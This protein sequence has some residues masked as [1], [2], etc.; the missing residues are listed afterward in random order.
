MAKPASGATIDSG[1]GDSTNLV[2]VWGLLEGSTTSSADST[3][4]GHTLTLSS[5]GLWGTDGNGD[6]ALV[7]AAGAAAPAAIASPISFT[8]AQSWT[9]A[10]RAKVGGANN[11]GMVAGDNSNT[12][13][14]IWMN[15]ANGTLQVRDHNT[16][17][18]TYTVSAANLQAL[19]D[20]EL[21]RDASGNTIALYR[22]GSLV[23]SQTCNSSTNGAFTFNTIGNSYTSTTFALVGT[24]TYVYLWNAAKGS[25]TAS[26]LASNPYSIFLAGGGGGGSPVGRIVRTR[27]AV[28]RASTY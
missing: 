15:A 7:I 3:G 24:I 5:S 19:A 26:N 23:Q 17:D 25:T 9:I 21:S 8:N 10:W 4:N 2:G 28:N 22:N 14:F 6:A 20:Y 12:T 1:N 13:D 11:L 16:T 27:Q 18:F